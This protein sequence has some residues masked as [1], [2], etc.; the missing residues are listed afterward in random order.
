MDRRLWVDVFEGDRL[1]VFIHNLP[2]TLTTGDLTKETA[3]HALALSILRLT[4]FSVTLAQFPSY[5]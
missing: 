4:L 1:L 3:I 2:G 5:L